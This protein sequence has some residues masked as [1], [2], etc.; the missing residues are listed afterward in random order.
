M[1]K[2]QLPQL[3]MN[4]QFGNQMMDQHQYSRQGAQGFVVNKNIY[5]E[6]GSPD[7]NDSHLMS[8]RANSFNPNNTF[9]EGVHKK[10]SGQSYK[11]QMNSPIRQSMANL[12]QVKKNSSNHRV[13]E[14]FKQTSNQLSNI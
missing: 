13:S 10:Q 1:G 4:Q 7:A 8:F 12:N 6:A 11:T 14:A 9:D 2:V 3:R 5:T